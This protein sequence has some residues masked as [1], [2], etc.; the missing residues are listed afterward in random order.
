MGFAYYKG[1]ETE[2]DF[3]TAVIW[4][5]KSAKEGFAEGLNN[6]GD[7]Y[8]YGIGVEQD[9]AKAR[10]CYKEAAEQNNAE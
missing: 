3:E 4:F 5:T 8:W 1:E 6:L 9:D 7:C 2:Q 10:E